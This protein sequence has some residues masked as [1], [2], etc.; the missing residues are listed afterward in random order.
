MSNKE[1]NSVSDIIKRIFDN[2]DVNQMDSA[3]QIT[4]VWKDILC[5]IQN[6]SSDNYG[7]KNNLGRKL[8]DHTKIIDLKNEILI[9]ETD[10]SGWI[11]TLQ[12]YNTYIMRGLKKNF[13]KLSI[14]SIAYRLKGTYSPANSGLEGMDKK[15]LSQE[16]KKVLEQSMP[17]S[18]L[19]DELKKRFENLKQSM[20][21]KEE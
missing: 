10:H 21:D 20:L 3:V 15:A 7:I 19:P 8:A 18:D 17:K 13:P 5:S 6:R 11:Q 1:V 14:K 16:D 9:V 4:T 2:I 12:L